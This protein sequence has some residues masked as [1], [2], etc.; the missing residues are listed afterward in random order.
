[1][2]ALMLIHFNPELHL[3]IKTDASEYALAGILLQF[4]SDGTW[5]SVA[6]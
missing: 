2:S 3:R 6:F 1:M 4:V 5:H